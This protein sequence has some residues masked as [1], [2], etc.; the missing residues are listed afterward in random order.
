MAALTIG[1][2]MSLLLMAWQ[3]QATLYSNLTPN[4]LVSPQAYADLLKASWILIDIISKHPQM[5]F[6]SPTSEYFQVQLLAE[7]CYF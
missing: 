2:Q 7:V 3:S 1:G 4:T 6:W 5:K